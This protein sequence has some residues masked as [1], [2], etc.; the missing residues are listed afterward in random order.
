M[1]NKVNGYNKQALWHSSLAGQVGQVPQQSSGQVMLVTVMALSGMILGATTIAGLLMIYQLRQSTDL[2]NSTRAIYAAD[3]GIEYE[4]YRIYKNSG[5]VAPVLSNGASF[6]TQKQSE[7]AI[8]VGKKTETI[9]VK[10]I[11]KSG[12]VA[13]A[14]EMI[15]RKTSVIP[16]Q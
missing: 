5:Y 4:L 6:E 12:K 13:R 9:T 14:F 3:A 11:G 1:I 15:L 16:A 8:D 10:S 2:I 7:S